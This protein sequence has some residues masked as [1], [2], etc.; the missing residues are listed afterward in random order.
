[1]FALASNET[2]PGPIY[3]P[4]IK[5]CATGPNGRGAEYTIPPRTFHVSMSEKKTRQDSAPGPKYTKP[6]SIG[7]QVESMY[8]SHQIVKFGTAERVTLG[9]MA[10]SSGDIGPGAYDHEGKEVQRRKLADVAS[11]AFHKK[12]WGG[13]PRFYS[14]R[15]VKAPGP[16]DYRLPSAIGGNNPE[17]RMRSAPAFAF[18]HGERSGRAHLPQQGRDTPGPQYSIGRTGFKTDPSMLFGTGSRF[19]PNETTPE[20]KSSHRASIDLARQRSARLSA[21]SKF[22][23]SA[24][25]TH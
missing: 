7:V 16:G 13:A 10:T 9:A 12:G 5:F 17:G 25:A 23:G 20:D 24:Q 2:G 1:M 19:L 3:R 4:N 21:S 22:G 11:T 18:P 15:V 8:P 14:D 6:Q